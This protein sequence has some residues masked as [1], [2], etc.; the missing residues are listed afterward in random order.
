MGYPSVMH[1]RQLGSDN[2]NFLNITSYYLPS[3]SD[4]P[5]VFSG[6]VVPALGR[7]FL[8]ITS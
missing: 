5:I 6:T 3:F 8:P 4:L 2:F 1:Y 7:I